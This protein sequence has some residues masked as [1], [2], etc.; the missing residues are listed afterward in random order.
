LISEEEQSV[1]RSEG[2]PPKKKKKQ[3]EA[4]GKKKG[5]KDILK[6]DGKRTLAMMY[7]DIKRTKPDDGN[8]GNVDAE[9]EG[10]A[11]SCDGSYCSADDL[12]AADLKIVQGG[13][14]DVIQ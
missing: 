14:L 8:G 4:K 7:N 12:S 5:Q 9:S 1:C 6:D 2:S 3:A 11:S 13:I 10:D